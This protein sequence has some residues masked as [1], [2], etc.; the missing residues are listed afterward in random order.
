MYQP[1][2]KYASYYQKCATAA[3]LMRF[4]AIIAFVVFFVFCIGFWRDNLTTDNLRY[5]VKYIDLSGADSTPSDAH[6]SV[7]GKEGSQYYMIGSDLAV[8]SSDG[9]G[10]YDFAGNKL[11]QY[12]HVYSAPCSLSNGKNVLVYDEKGTEMALYGPVSKLY[13]RTF[14][15]PVKSACLNDMGCFAVVTAEKNYR[16]GVVVYTYH[17]DAH[18]NEYEEVFTWMTPSKYVMSCALNANASRVV[19]ASAEAKSGSFVTEVLV[20]NTTKSADQ[21]LEKSVIFTDMLPLKVGYAENDSVIWLLTDR[22]FILLDK[23]LEQTAVVPY[24][25]QSAGLF[26]AYDDVFVLV[27]QEGLAG[28]AMTVNGYAYD[29]TLVFS[30]AT[31]KKV[32]DIEYRDETLYLLMADSLA[33]YDVAQSEKPTELAVIPLAVRYQSVRADNYLRYVLVSA[34]KAERHSLA[35]LLE[36]G[37]EQ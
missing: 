22:A 7:P 31:D 33:I 9:V 29:G 6:I 8:V 17:K 23:E 12:D 34:K 13:S 26:R 4:A 25:S 18:F 24:V 14:E 3:K 37:K 11:Y 27:K 21:A 1:E 36:N 28:N 10:L 15:Y 5:L 30:L 35:S 19:C 20:Y 32:T 2:K 16:S